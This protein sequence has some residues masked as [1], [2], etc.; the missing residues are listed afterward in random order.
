MGAMGTWLVTLGARARPTLGGVP[1]FADPEAAR[2]AAQ[3]GCSPAVT[4]DAA[5]VRGIVLRTQYFDHLT[6]QFFQRYPHGM[7]VVLGAG[8]CT[9]FSRLAR[10]LAAH[11]T[12]DPA[13]SRW[14]N[15]DLPPVC[16]L[17]EQF[18]PCAVGERNV[19]CS[20]LDVQWLHSAQLSAGRPLLV[21]LEGVC[22]YLPQQP[23][24]DMLRAF[25]A[26]C[27][28]QA[29]D[30]TLVLDFVHPA[31]LGQPMQA[32]GMELPLASGFAQASEIAALHPALRLLEQRH[33]Y[34]QFSQRH[35]QFAAAFA[36][37]WGQPPYTMAAFAV[38]PVQ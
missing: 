23:L 31:L 22:P 27:A 28:A 32:G 36:E 2:I 19:V 4:A 15:I 25:A 20:A 26:H 35:Q 21:L 12:P 7:S 16:A 24:Q 14:I 37:R 9:R 34:A 1:G 6:L 3:L 8:L 10:Q 38:D 18:L 17:R 13:G 33:P 11:R 30:A 29:I 5:V